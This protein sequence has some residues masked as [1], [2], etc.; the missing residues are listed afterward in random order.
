MSTGMPAGIWLN[1]FGTIIED[2]FG[3]TAYHVGSS[4]TSKQWRD[5]DV[6][7]LLPDEEF[8]RLFGQPESSEVN[9]KLAAITLAFCALGKAMT[10]LPIDFQIQKQTTAN[11]K[12]PNRRSALVEIEPRLTTAA[13]PVDEPE[14]SATADEPTIATELPDGASPGKLGGIASCRAQD[15]VKHTCEVCGREGSRRFVQTE[16]GWKCSPSATACAPRF[17]A[18][19]AKP[20][21]P[22]PTP[23]GMATVR[24]LDSIATPVAG[25]VIEKPSQTLAHAEV[26]QLA[27]A[28]A[29]DEVTARCDSCNWTWNLTGRVLRQAVQ[30]HELKHEGHMVD[31][32]DGADQ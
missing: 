24:Q 2:Y 29:K 6:R 19:G 26:A 11:E 25:R 15:A 8:D 10:G 31:V 12:Y 1:K 9:S 17:L 20:S 22:R 21:R 3:H 23:N 28:I 13:E 32:V 14:N 27:D 30:L 5:V 16:T 4:L 18:P 7:L